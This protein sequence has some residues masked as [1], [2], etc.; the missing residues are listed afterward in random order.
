MGR[1]LRRGDISDVIWKD[2]SFPIKR[3][4]PPNATTEVVGGWI[5]DSN[6]TP[7]ISPPN[8]ELK[9]GRILLCRPGRTLERRYF[10]LFSSQ[11]T[12]SQF[13]P[14]LSSCS[15]PCLL[16]DG[17]WIQ[18]RTRAVLILI[19]I[20][21]LSTGT[22]SIVREIF[23]NLITTGIPASI[24]TWSIHLSIQYFKFLWKYF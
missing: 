7:S 19:R 5:M 9:T 13:F 21:D 18:I 17:P 4:L 23:I 14:C 24:G 12:R 11:K 22:F 16:L 8:S 20:S 6:H 15:S 3:E 10:I 2:N 1:D